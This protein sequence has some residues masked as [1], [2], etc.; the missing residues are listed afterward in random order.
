VPAEESAA[1]PL[2]EAHR[3]FDRGDFAV[4]GRLARS[5][6]QTAEDDATRAAADALL[7]RLSVDPLIVWLSAGCL[8]FFA[9]VLTLM[10]G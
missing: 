6:K 3:A 7:A 4:A 5:L 10:R 1:P 2:D 9:L 8:V